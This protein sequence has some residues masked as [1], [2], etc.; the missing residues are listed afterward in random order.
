MDPPLE[1]FEEGLDRVNRV[2]NHLTQV[3]LGRR[4]LSMARYRVLRYLQSRNEVNMSQM[5][6]HLLV[7]AP[8]LTELVDGLVRSGLV[9]RLRDQGDR[10]MVFLRLTGAGRELYRE[11]LD[12]RC[13]CLEEVLDGY[14][15]GLADVNNLLGD[16]YTRLKKKIIAPG[17]SLAGRTGKEG[18]AGDFD[19]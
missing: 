9:D 4:G 1:L 11:V 17:G 14:E 2:L 6:G 12:F 10:R 19:C 5:Q 3:F 8:T 15:T 18:C 13:N 16:V 7:S